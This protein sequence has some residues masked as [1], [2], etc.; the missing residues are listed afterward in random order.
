[1]QTNKA[2]ICQDRTHYCPLTWQEITY[3]IDSNECYNNND[4]IELPTGEI[5]KVTG[6]YETCPPKVAGVKL[7]SEPLAVPEGRRVKFEYEAM[8]AD[9]MV[10][11]HISTY[12]W[13]PSVEG[14]KAALAEAFSAGFEAG[15]NYAFKSQGEV[16]S[17]IIYGRQDH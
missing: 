1:M 17:K 15:Y 16:K 12:D 14:V 13:C 4:P 11:H 6:W 5:V 10:K 9:I 8:I 2:S 3:Y 7:Y